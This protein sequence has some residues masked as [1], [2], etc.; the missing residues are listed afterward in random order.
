[1]ATFILPGGEITIR[2]TSRDMGDIIRAAATLRAS[3]FITIDEWDHAQDLPIW[4]V[5]DM[6]TVNR[7]SPVPGEVSIRDPI[8]RF[9]AET[10][11]AAVMF[12][13]HY[14]GAHR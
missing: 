6:R 4:G 3:H 5:F 8:K 9:T 1:M 12:A 11:D 2:F 7:N 14:Q 13:V 10:P